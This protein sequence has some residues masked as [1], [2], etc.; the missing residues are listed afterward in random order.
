M[1]NE[2]SPDAPH[3]C[4]ESTL[5]GPFALVSDPRNVS[6]RAVATLLPLLFACI[7]A[8]SDTDIVPWAPGSP[9]QLGPAEAGPFAHEPAAIDGFLPFCRLPDGV[10]TLEPP[11]IDLTN[12]DAL[13]APDALPKFEIYVSEAGWREA[14]DHA[15]AYADWMNLRA[16][17]VET[18][19]EPDH[20]YVHAALRI[21]GELWPDVGLRIR[22]RSNLYVH[23]YNLRNRPIPGALERCYADRLP[24]KPSLRVAVDAWDGDSRFLR[25]RSLNFVAREGS[26][27]G[28]LR[29]VA[30]LHV[31]REAGV[32]APR[33]THARLCVNG[34]YYGLFTLTEE[35]DTQEFLDAAFPGRSEGDYWK[36]ETDGSQWWDE[37]LLA[38]LPWYERYRPVA[39]TTRQDPGALGRLL[40]AGTAIRAGDPIAPLDD[41]LD[42]EEWLW[43]VAVDMAAPDY[44]GMMG[45][46]K[47]HLLYDHP[48]R[49]LLVVPYD[50]DLS[51]VDLGRYLHGLCEG[52][53][54][55]ANPCW[56]RVRSRPKVAGW[57]L[58]TYPFEY[59]QT[60]RA[61][62]DGPLNPTTL[63]PWIAARRD[64]IRPWVEADRYHREGAPPCDV[65]PTY[66]LYYGLDAW[67]YESGP[68]L[69]ADIL[70]RAAA[71]E[72]QLAGERT[73]EESCRPGAGRVE[74]PY[75]ILP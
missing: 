11:P 70:G 24:L 7:P 52:D 1:R 26:D 9:E 33:S 39:G 57:L 59:E 13:F 8:C 22:G 44:D 50:R 29:E 69:E 51:F 67:E 63:L 4:G 56:S 35:A 42:R 68:L 17:H 60:L 61:V 40:D 21:Q 72:R 16:R 47:N 41:L 38:E 75:E 6:I 3:R 46:H 15:K 45:N 30:S 12:D 74:L 5:P 32:P 23:F 65:D 54:H 37:S 19:E 27:A 71:V 10:E 64:A 53:I 43:A 28:Y 20:G 49:G 73:C 48:D 2:P 31:L 14:C 62:T 55:G 58:D 36:V 18:T 66:C 34:H 25:N